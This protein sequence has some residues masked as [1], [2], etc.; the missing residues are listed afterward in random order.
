MR[1]I[2]ADALLEK[3]FGKRGGLIHTADVDLMPTVDAVP[4]VRCKDCKHS[5]RWYRDRVRC[6]LWCE[7]G[8]GV[9][10]DGYCNYAERKNN[11]PMR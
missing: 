4:V 7:T 9:F 11:G 1:L 5:E 10:E 2:D 3:A 8:I 6:F